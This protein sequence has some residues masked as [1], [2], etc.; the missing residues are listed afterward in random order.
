MHRYE[1]IFDNAVAQHDCGIA[2]FIILA[3]CLFVY[4]F[5]GIGFIC[6]VLGYDF[7]R[8]YSAPLCICPGVVTNQPDSVVHPGVPLRE[9]LKRTQKFPNIKVI[10]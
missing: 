4:L 10:F 7:R 9:Y 3:D 2:N 8:Q 5:I 1:A 6:P